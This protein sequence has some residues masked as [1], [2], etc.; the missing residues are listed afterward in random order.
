M[1]GWAAL[2]LLGAVTPTATQ[3]VRQAPPAWEARAVTPAADEVAAATYVVKPGDTLS[4]VVE[5]T[6][7]GADAIARANKLAPP[8]ALR[9]GQKLAIPPGRYHRVRRGEAGIAIARAYGVEWARIT[10]LNHLEPPY[11]LRAGDRLL[12]PSAGEVAKM[13]LEQRAAAF[14][15]DIDDLVTGSE[16]ALAPK[17]APAPPS[18]SPTRTLAPTTPV[19]A[20]ETRFDGR[21][22]WPLVGKVIRAFGALPNG[23]RNDGINLAATLGE[24]IQAAADGIVAYA[25]SLAAFGQL[26]LIRHGDGWL[27]AYGHAQ[28]L[29]VTRGQAV[30]RGQTIARAGATGSAGTP[31]L[32]FEIRQGRRPVNPVGLL[33]RVG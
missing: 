23:T 17:A 5:K 3:P 32:H 8:F 24:P 6:N 19:A 10:A 27:T 28:T 20:P 4:H 16:P 22:G 1:S 21:F 18:P 13:T 25:G 33:P 12:I 7:A 15:I 11:Q 29:L 14:R 30:S 9:P 31:Q 26:I 2:A